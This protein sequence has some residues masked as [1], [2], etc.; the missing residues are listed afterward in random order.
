M[1]AKHLF[2]IALL[3]LAMLTTAQDSD[4][5]KPTGYV[6]INGG[7]S[8]PLGEFSDVYIGGASTGSNFNVA[9]GIPFLFKNHMG[10]ATNFSTCAYGAS[11]QPFIEQQIN[12]LESIGYQYGTDFTFK[13]RSG[14]VSYS[15][16]RILIGMYS[17]IP[18]KKRLSIDSRILFGVNFVDRPDFVIYLNDTRD[19]Y[20]ATYKQYSTNTTAFAFDLGI[21]VR[22][23]LGKKQRL[24]ITVNFDYVGSTANF[25][26]KSK[27]IYKTSDNSLDD[28]EIKT[29]TQSYSVSS[30][31]TTV[32]FG[33]VFGNK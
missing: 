24:C 9:Y 13:S 6:S 3:Q 27:S 15:Q 8:S 28:S 7:S 23:N 33:Y 10:L 18:L 4:K 2:T 22:Y 14:D 25:Y 30:F 11:D 32:G 16:Y 20:T 5:A 26:V 17:T 31:N 19:N 21:G 1:K 12:L 29:V